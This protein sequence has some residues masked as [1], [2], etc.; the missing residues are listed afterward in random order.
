[1]ICSSMCL[2]KWRMKESVVDLINISPT[3]VAYTV[4]D[5]VSNRAVELLQNLGYEP[6]VTEALCESIYCRS[7]NGGI[8]RGYCENRYS[9]S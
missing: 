5:N 7:W 1:M 4:S 2:K 9:F 3:G 8:P 6:I